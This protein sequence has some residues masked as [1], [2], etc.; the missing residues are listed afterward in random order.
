M[1]E[2]EAEIRALETELADPAL[3]EKDN[4]TFNKKAARLDAARLELEGYE[5]EW[6]ELEEKKEQLS[7]NGD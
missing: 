4:A 2:R 7:I 5:E 6:L 3:F 1:P